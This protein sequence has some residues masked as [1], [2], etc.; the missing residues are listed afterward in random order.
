MLS[1]LD[2]DQA[3]V[4]TK[5]FTGTPI[6][7]LAMPNSSSVLPGRNALKDEHHSLMFQIVGVALAAPLS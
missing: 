6:Q 1:G 4:P 2:F 3:V 7:T 5:M